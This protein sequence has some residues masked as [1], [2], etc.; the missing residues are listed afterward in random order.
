VL[1][2]G[3]SASCDKGGALRSAM[4]REAER[5]VGAAGSGAATAFMAA[6]ACS[7]PLAHAMCRCVAG[8]RRFTPSPLVKA[9]AQVAR[10]TLR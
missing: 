3:A 9:F 1:R 10:R 7:A 6:C 5:A 8:A 2:D 4:L